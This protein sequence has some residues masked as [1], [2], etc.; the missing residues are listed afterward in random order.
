MQQS[1]ESTM[2]MT[3]SDNS[4]PDSKDEA[5]EVRLVRPPASTLKAP[6]KKAINRTT[7]VVETLTTNVKCRCGV[8]LEWR[9]PSQSGKAPKG[10]FVCSDAQRHKEESGEW[11]QT[12]G[13]YAWVDAREISTIPICYCGM[14]CNL[15]KPKESDEKQRPPFWRCPRKTVYG[16]TDACRF[17]LA[18]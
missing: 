3:T 2:K 8:E 16:S 18:Q 10:Y 14:A 7:P 5:L 4:L 13:C 9:P 1:L 12:T 15:K 11:I 17:Y 6:K